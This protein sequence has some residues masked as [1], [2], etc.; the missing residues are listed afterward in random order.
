MFVKLLNDGF[1]MSSLI[2]IMVAPLREMGVFDMVRL[3]N[4]HREGQE[5]EN[6]QVSDLENL[7]TGPSLLLK[8]ICICIGMA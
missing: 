6:T 4:P 2:S 5:G 3:E 8:A 7:L 1:S